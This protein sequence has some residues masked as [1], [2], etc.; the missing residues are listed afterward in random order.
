MLIRS[1]RSYF[2]Q[3]QL[4]N[5]HHQGLGLVFLDETLTIYYVIVGDKLLHRQL[6]TGGR[7][8]WSVRHPVPVPGGAAA[9]LE[10]PGVPLPVLSFLPGTC[11]CLPA[12][13]TGTPMSSVS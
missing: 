9:A 3:Q 1:S 2:Q 7:D 4:K 5:K 6:G 8:Y 10:P 13:Q 12:N 11:Y